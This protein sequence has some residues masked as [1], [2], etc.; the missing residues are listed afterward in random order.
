IIIHNMELI[1]GLL[2][3]KIA[4]HEFGIDDIDILNAIQYH[5]TGRKAMAP[6]EKIIFISDYIEPGRSFPGVEPVRKLAY[7]NLDKSIVLAIDQTIKFLI[8]N[9]RLIHINTIR[10]RNY[11]KIEMIEKGGSK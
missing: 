5:T 6:L 3:S 7:E 9:D 4:K 11:I 8:N 10:A 2:G 1:H